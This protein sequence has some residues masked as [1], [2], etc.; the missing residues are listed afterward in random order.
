MVA[1]T[2]ID[3]RLHCIDLAF[4]GS[5]TVIA[6]YLLHTEDE[7]ALIET[8]PGSTIPALLAGLDALQVDPEQITA[9]LVTH[10][11]LDHAGAAG[12]LLH[13]FPNA[14]LYAH[15]IGVP[16]LLDPSR[17]LASATRIYG[18]MMGPLWGETVPVPPGRVTALEDGDIVTVA[19]HELHTI[20]T[21]G[22]ASHHVVFHDPERRI[23][24][25]GDVAAVRL[26][27][28][29]YVRPPTPPPEVDL[30][31]W[32]ESIERIR[33]LTP[34]TV[35]L[36]HFGP[37]ADVD[38]HLDEAERRLLEWAAVV[39][40]A[41]AAGQDRPAIVD[42][43]QLRGDEELLR[44][45]SDAGVVHRYELAAPYGMSTDG[46]IRYFRKRGAVNS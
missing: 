5:P 17:L 41:L 35:A 26:P 40:R 46:L 29:E 6:A 36:T 44:Q 33:A 2:S 24:F 45:T 12:A 1:P 28:F 34:R 15:E 23:V 7:Y 42:T 13:R 14:H 37:Y 25:A 22:H 20:Y 31:L 32:R 3:D 9:L 43:I 21:P 16:H 10:I 39:E 8:G 27:G 11:H 4:Q 30:D 38:R 18:E 19:R